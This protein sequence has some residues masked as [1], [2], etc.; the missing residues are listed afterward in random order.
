MGSLAS[1]SNLPRD[2]GPFLEQRLVGAQDRTQ[3]AYHDPHGELGWGRSP[4]LETALWRRCLSAGPERW[5][6]GAWAAA[7][8]SRSPLFESPSRGAAVQVCALSLVCVPL[9]LAQ[10]AEGQWGA[11][12]V[13]G[14]PLC[15]LPAPAVRTQVTR[16]LGVMLTLYQV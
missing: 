15:S 10:S 14:Q 9:N 4:G 8:F 1:A 11:W 2:P 6:Q 7:K 16:A 13:T 3:G 12:Q 5:G